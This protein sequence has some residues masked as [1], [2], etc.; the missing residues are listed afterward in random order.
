MRQRSGFWRITKT[1]DAVH[2]T[3]KAGRNI[4]EKYQPCV[5]ALRRRAREW[6]GKLTIENE[7]APRRGTAED[8]DKLM[9]SY[10]NDP[11]GTMKVMEQMFGTAQYPDVLKTLSSRL[12]TSTRPGVGAHGKIQNRASR[13]WASAR[14][15]RSRERWRPERVQKQRES[16]IEKR[17]P[18]W[19]K[20]IEGDPEHAAM[21]ERL[22]GMTRILFN[23]GKLK[24]DERPAD[25]N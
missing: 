16:D 8:F 21:L 23:L 1:E 9:A 5:S 4:E 15:R 19:F 12:R 7:D 17:K 22:G 14:P 6:V 24:D 2:D 10:V 20:P 11:G 18:A 3:E 25:W 13:S